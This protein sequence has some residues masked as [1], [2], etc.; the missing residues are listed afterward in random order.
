MATRK[1]IPLNISRP[2]KFD[3]FKLS[4]QDSAH[5]QVN[6]IPYRYPFADIA[7]YDALK[8]LGYFRAESKN[9]STAE[10]GGSNTAHTRSNLGFQLPHTE[11]LILLCRVKSNLSSGKKITITIKGSEQYSIPDET[12]VLTQA[13][14]GGDLQVVAGD[15]FE[16]DLY[17]FGLLIDAHGEIQIH[18]EDDASSNADAEKLEFALIARMG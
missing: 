18:T 13:S 1:H 11:K 17:E 16:I 2:G 10:L 4:F 15:Q 3:V 9:V 5:E 12:M 7:E 8:D 6:I 14:S